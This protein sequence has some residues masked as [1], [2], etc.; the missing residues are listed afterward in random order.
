MRGTGGSLLPLVAR[1][2]HNDFAGFSE[3]FC[4]N[5]RSDECIQLA[6]APRSV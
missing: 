4:L 1:V 2:C 6:L 3:H 5:F